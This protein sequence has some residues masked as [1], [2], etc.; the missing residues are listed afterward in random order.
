MHSVENIDGKENKTGKGNNQNVAK[1]IK[2]KEYIDVSFNKKV[3]RHNVERIQSNFH[4]IGTY[5]GCKIYLSCFDDKRSILDDGIN[6]LAY[7]HK[8]ARSK[9]E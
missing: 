3:V 6:I 8:D 4:K 7:F 5:D 2:H 9:I 1:N